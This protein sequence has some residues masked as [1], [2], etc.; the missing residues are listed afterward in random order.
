MRFTQNEGLP[1]LFMLM[2]NAVSANAANG[3][4]IQP[5]YSTDI[6]TYMDGIPI[7]GYN[8][9]GQTLICLE[10]LSNYGFS[11][12]YCDEVRL[13]NNFLWKKSF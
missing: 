6:L 9:G 2:F 8:I 10:D 3:D 11:V 5:I 7:K 4:V 13:I 12:Y 1:R